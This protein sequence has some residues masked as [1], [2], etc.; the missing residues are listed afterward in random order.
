MK[1]NYYVYIREGYIEFFTTLEEAQK[2]AKKHGKKVH[3]S[4]HSKTVK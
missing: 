1:A 4:E 2:V 3:E